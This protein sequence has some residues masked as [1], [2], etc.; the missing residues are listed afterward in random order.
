MRYIKVFTGHRKWSY[1]RTIFFE[2]VVLRSWNNSCYKPDIQ[3]EPS[4]LRKAIFIIDEMQTKDPLRSRK[5][6][7][8]DWNIIF[9]R[10][11]IK[12][13]P[14][15]PRR[16]ARKLI[17]KSSNSGVKNYPHKK[18]IEC[19]PPHRSKIKISLKAVNGG[20]I[21]K[22]SLWPRRAFEG[23][24]REDNY[25]SRGDIFSE[26]IFSLRILKK[27]FIQIMPL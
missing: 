16:A 6:F 26:G 17:R 9:T 5:A 24:G 4:K 14:S 8:R 11:Y 10:S 25:H 20:T 21:K 22:D 15:G 13:G 23:A 12:K 2:N 27:I 19:D 7:R 3:R 1:Q 18:K